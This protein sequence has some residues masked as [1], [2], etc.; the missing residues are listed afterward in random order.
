M[1]SR[2]NSHEVGRWPASCREF[3]SSRRMAFGLLMNPGMSQK[4]VEVV[5]GR[6]ATDE[7]LRARFSADP[8]STLEHLRENG[9]DLTPGEV[10]ALRETPAALWELVASGIHPRLQKIALKADP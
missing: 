6:L 3:D 10:Q 8:S 7:A 2:R 1:P 5:I 4:C 9:F